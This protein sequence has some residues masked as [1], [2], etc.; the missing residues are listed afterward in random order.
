MPSPLAVDLSQGRCGGGLG[1]EGLLSP[2]LP[3]QGPCPDREQW[4]TIKLRVVSY[5]ALSLAAERGRVSEEGIAFSPAKPALLAKQLDSAGI[6]CAAIQEARTA[7]G[8]VNTGSYLR[9]C[10]GCRSGHLG[11]ELWFRSGHPL[12]DNGSG[13]EASV[14]FDLAHFVVLFQDPR[15]LAVLFRKGGCQLVFAA[16]H[17]PHRGHIMEGK[18][19]TNREGSSTRVCSNGDYGHRQL[20]HMCKKGQPGPLLSAGTAPLLALILSSCLCNGTLAGFARGRTRQS[21]R[22]IWSWTTLPRLLK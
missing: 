11:V 13:G 6:H 2:F 15:R 3:Q 5:N 22:P 20:S 17:A 16:L 18:S 10:S 14:R 8:Y 19:R 7:E 1:A 21:W 9:F 12:W 4:G